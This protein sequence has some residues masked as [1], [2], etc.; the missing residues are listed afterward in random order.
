MKPFVI[1]L[2]LVLVVTGCRTSGPKFDPLATPAAPASEGHFA[3]AGLTNHL[4][5]SML[6]PSAEP[7]RLGP[8]DVIEI[9]TLGET[10]S[11]V[12]VPVELGLV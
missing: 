11:S 1:I 7:Y 5:Q 2:A 6:A 9:E 4:T 10:K 3:P 12:M 8:G